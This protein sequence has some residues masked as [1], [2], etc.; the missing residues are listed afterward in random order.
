VAEWE[1][2]AAW[3]KKSDRKSVWDM[4]MTIHTEDP[5]GALPTHRQRFRVDAPYMVEFALDYPTPQTDKVDVEITTPSGE[6]EKLT[7]ILIDREPQAGEFKL[8]VSVATGETDVRLG[9]PLEVGST[10]NVTYRLGHL[11]ADFDF[12]AYLHESMALGL[13][14]CL[15]IDSV[16]WV[17]LWVLFVVYWGIARAAPERT[18]FCF[19]AML[20]GIYFIIALLAALDAHL[21]H[22]CEMLC[23]RHLHNQHAEYRERAKSITATRLSCARSELMSPVQP[24]SANSVP[25]S[26]STSPAIY[27]D[28]DGEESRLIS[29]PTSYIKPS[30][31]HTYERGDKSRTISPTGSYHR[32]SVASTLSRMSVFVTQRRVSMALTIGEDLTQIRSDRR[33]IDDNSGVV[34]PNYFHAEKYDSPRYHQTEA[35]P[36]MHSGRLSKML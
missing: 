30:P 15:E 9:R 36:S 3:Y 29:P 21:H 17:C 20:F 5:V 26:F 7:A 4:M 23:P 13:I 32:R 11:P 2:K 12:H 22:V 35:P 31:M 8:V 25:V 14:H 24:W 34:H 28:E 16:T 27:E 1:T 18:D 10:V 19:Y 6:E 33:R